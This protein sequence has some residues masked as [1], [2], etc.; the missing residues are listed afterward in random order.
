MQSN[1]ERIALVPGSFDPFTVGHRDVVEKAAKAFD[2]VVVAVMINDKKK[3]MLSSEQRV[4][5]ARLSLS[6][7]PNVEVVYDGGMLTDLFERI[8]ASAIVKGIRN[9][10]D[11]AY[12]NEMA[13]YNTERDPRAVTLYVSASDGL[14]RVSS[15]A[16]RS[17]SDAP[18]E[19]LTY[20]C[21]L[22]REYVKEII[23]KR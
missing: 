16:A 3:Y 22:A 7:L 17:C 18:N 9:A 8:G 2:R 12:E 1:N 19:F 13:K 10:D 14:T 21:P 15:T 4:T 6:D 23:D 5:I 20:I 11:L